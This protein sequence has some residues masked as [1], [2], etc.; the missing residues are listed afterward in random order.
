MRPQHRG[1]EGELAAP[2]RAD[3]VEELHARRHGDEHRHDREERQEHLAR[4]VHVVGP[5]RDRQRSD[6]DRRVDEGLVAEDRLA[7]EHREDLGDDPEE[8]Q[9]D[10]VDLWVPEE[11][12]DVLPEH[13]AAAVRVEDVRTEASVG[14]EREERGGQGREDEEHE[15]R[16]DE[17][18]PHEDRHPEHRHAGRAHREDRRDEVDRPED[19]AE[20][21][22]RQAEDPEVAAHAGAVGGVGQRRVGEP[23]EGRRATGGEEATG[24]DEPTEEV[25]PVGEHVE[26][27]ERHVGRAD[28][29]RHERVGEGGEQRRREQQQHDRAVHREHLV[30]LV[31]VVHD[32]HARAAISSARMMSA[33]SAAQEEPRRT[34]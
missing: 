12:E 6:G 34:R 20:T 24:R 32:L 11:P 17:D 28:L 16:G 9:G 5:D 27:R 23:A 14:A 1:V 15:D 18:G 19:G 25:E 2:H 10:D 30:V 7:R 3:P 26:P 13:H 8:R 4:A 29:Q 22:E 33:M 31:G 21:A